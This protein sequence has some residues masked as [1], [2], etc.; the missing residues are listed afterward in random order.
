VGRVYRVKEIFYSLQGEG[1]RA[2]VPVSFVRFAGCNLSC[3]FCDTDFKGGDRMSA[4]DVLAECQRIGVAK[5]VVFTGGEPSLQLDDE[6]IQLFTEQGWHTAVET[7]GTHTLPSGITWITCSPKPD[8]KVVLALVNELKYVL[9]AG[10]PLPEPDC[11]TEHYLISP[12]FDGLKPVPANIAWCVDLVLKNPRW[13]LTMQYHK[14]AFGG[15]R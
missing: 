8:G 2:G 9:S 3:W 1:M 5:N 6:I 14:T 13:Q 7:N 10:D 4:F 12:C 15:L 11:A